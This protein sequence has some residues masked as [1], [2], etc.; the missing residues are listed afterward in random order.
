MSS[1]NFYDDWVT[2]NKKKEIEA[3]AKQQEDILISALKSEKNSAL[4][5]VNLSTNN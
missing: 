4:T 3:I 2:N 1:E 5:F